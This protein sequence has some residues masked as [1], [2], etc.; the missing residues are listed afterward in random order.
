MSV[1][2]IRSA[3]EN[4]YDFSVLVINI[5]VNTGKVLSLHQ[6]DVRRRAARHLDVG[7]DVAG[8]VDGGRVAVEFYFHGVGVDGIDA[9]GADDDGQHGE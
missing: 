2:I 7:T 3:G 9:T 4:I 6:L 5:G 8:Y 1:A